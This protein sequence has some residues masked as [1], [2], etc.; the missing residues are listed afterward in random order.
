MFLCFK[1]SF[2]TV[3]NANLLICVRCL[4]P[5]IFLKS[6]VH[7]TPMIQFALNVLVDRGLRPQCVM[8]FN[9]WKHNVGLKNI[10]K[11]EPI[12][13][14]FMYNARLKRA[15]KLEV[16]MAFLSQFWLFNVKNA[17]FI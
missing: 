13:F 6:G 9:K 4:W 16:Q 12:L 10:V 1:F 14:K 11:L 17:F 3:F 5:N 7:W 2:I 8:R 15:S